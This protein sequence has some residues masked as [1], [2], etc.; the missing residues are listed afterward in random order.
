MIFF[1]DAF[2]IMFGPHT[3]CFRFAP[4]LSVSGSEI[5]ADCWPVLVTVTEDEGDP[6]MSVSWFVPPGGQ[7]SE[8]SD[9]LVKLESKPGVAIFIR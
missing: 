5:P 8:L 7:K 3:S 2:K 9:P 4:C 1:N 6:K